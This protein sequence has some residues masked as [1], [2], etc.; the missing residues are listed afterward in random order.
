M[1]KDLENVI[2]CRKGEKIKTTTLEGIQIDL[3][4][5]TDVLELMR[6]TMEPGASFGPPYKHVGQEAHLI[7]KGE[8]EVQVDEQTY[9]LKE[10]DTIWFS[11]LLPHTMKNLGKEKLI[12]CS[13]VSPPTFI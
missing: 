12:F 8:I 1:K 5:K 13:V 4:V 7:L 6:T 3:F 2:I 11:S 9:S 10:G